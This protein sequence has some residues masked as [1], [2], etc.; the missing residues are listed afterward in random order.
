[1]DKWIK[2]AQEELTT[3]K[4]EY[5]SVRMENGKPVEFTEERELYCIHNL[6]DLR[7]YVNAYKTEQKQSDDHPLSNMLEVYVSNCLVD[8]DSSQAPNIAAY[9]KNIGYF[10][11]R[12]CLIKSNIPPAESI[13]LSNTY[14]ER[15]IHY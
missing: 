14:I 11:I 6:D 7:N 10:H 4:V 12:N 3:K 2:A 9:I 5:K 8:I 1:M 15:T 13:T